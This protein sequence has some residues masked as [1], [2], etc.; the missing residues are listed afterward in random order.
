MIPHPQ[1][2][3][4][5][6]A[7]SYGFQPFPNATS[8]IGQTNERISD[9]WWQG[10]PST[11]SRGLGRWW[12]AGGPE[13]AE[14]P[15]EGANARVSLGMQRLMGIFTIG[16]PRGQE[17]WEGCPRGLTLM[18]ESCAPRT[19]LCWPTRIIQLVAIMTWVSRRWW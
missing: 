15:L 14:D 19:N 10:L 6:R 2:R 7:S 4:P 5:D 18:G 16:G 3:F 1:I 9:P 12:K 11:A 17:G 13:G 8:P